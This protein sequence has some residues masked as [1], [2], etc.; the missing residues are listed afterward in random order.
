MKQI[1]N[2]CGWIKRIWKEWRGELLVTALFLPLFWYLM[3]SGYLNDSA[4]ISRGTA[5]VL[6]IWTAAALIFVLRGNMSWERGALL[7]LLCGL[8]MRVGYAL[9]T[10]SYI[11]HHDYGDIWWF[12]YGHTEQL[13]VN[14]YGHA[15]YILYLYLNRSLP[16]FNV[17][18]FY[19]PP[20]FHILAALSMRVTYK[21]VGIEDLIYLFEASKIIS[22]LASCYTLLLVPKIC[23]ELKLRGA[24]AFAVVGVMSF[25]PLFYLMAGWVNNDGLVLF[26]MVWILLYSIRW[27]RKP[28]WGNTVFLALGF[29]L[30]MMSKLSCG[31]LAFFTG[32]LMLARLLYQMNDGRRGETVYPLTVKGLLLRFAAFGAVAFPLGLAYPVRNYLKFNQAFHYVLRLDIP[33]VPVLDFARRFL[34]FPVDR[35]FSPVFADPAEYHLNLFLLKTASFGEFSYSPELEGWGIA[36]VASNLALILLAVFSLILTWRSSRGFLRRW[37]MPGLWLLLYGSALAFAWDYPYTCSMD[38]RYVALTVLLGA[39]YLGFGV[40]RGVQGMKT[41]KGLLGRSLWLL[42]VLACL[43]AVT[44]LGVS[45]CYFFLNL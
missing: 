31:L 28:S 45:G 42:Y 36:I 14:D 9:G 26:F 19:H 32:A 23:R 25:L 33:E 37:A 15:P 3:D 6:C 2:R 7:L 1:W 27:Y 24:G 12:V 38:A 35:L 11:R 39:L 5:G 21:L 17:G 13:N 30:G 34:L 4:M 41:G 44:A 8:T 18:Q 16:D 22:C 40:E 20:L 29:G 43:G 10:N